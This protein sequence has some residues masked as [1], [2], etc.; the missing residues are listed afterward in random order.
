MSQGDSVTYS[1]RRK[2]KLAV[3]AACFNVGSNA[4]GDAQSSVYMNKSSEEMTQSENV[5]SFV[6]DNH[7]CMHKSSEKMTQC[8][9]NVLSLSVDDLKL[10][11]R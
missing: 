3:N 4:G 8:A 7:W 9:E 6:V 2:D 1:P 11:K 5:L 10:P